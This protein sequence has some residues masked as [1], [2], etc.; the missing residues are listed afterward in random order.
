M[1]AEVGTSRPH[2]HRLFQN[3]KKKIKY[4]NLHCITRKSLL[5]IKTPEHKNKEELLL[6]AT[7]G[8][9]W[10]KSQKGAAAMDRMECLI[11]AKASKDAG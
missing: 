5:K 10:S 1:S 7:L 4:L 3:I 8:K 9:P 2:A 6:K 11:S